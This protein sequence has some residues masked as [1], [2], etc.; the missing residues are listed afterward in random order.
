ML[1][2]GTQGHMM[3]TQYTTVVYVYM[4][5]ELKLERN[6]L[7]GMHAQLRSLLESILSNCI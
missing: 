5:Q 3:H 6:P 4:E 1:Y 7:L 2:G